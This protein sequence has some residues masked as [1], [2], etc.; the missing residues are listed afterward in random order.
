MDFELGDR[1]FA[2]LHS[3]LGLV[4]SILFEAAE[5]VV[6]RMHKNDF[7][8]NHDFTLVE[9][10]CDDGALV[11]NDEYFLVL[12]FLLENQTFL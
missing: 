3:V 11:A 5:H 4:G 1:L 7:L 12:V 2:G 10:D 9:D 8:E 6:A